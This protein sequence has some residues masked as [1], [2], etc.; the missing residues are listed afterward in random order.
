MMKQGR[1]KDD[2]LAVDY[3]GKLSEI[4]SPGA[5]RET[6]IHYKLVG[7][8]FL[9]S[10]HSLFFLTRVPIFSGPDEARVE[11]RDRGEIQMEAEGG[12]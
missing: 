3:P 9:P 10:R 7:R 1:K 2:Q 12:R 6:R 5:S 11:S 8:A 4:T